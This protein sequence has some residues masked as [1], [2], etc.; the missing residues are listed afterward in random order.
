MELS[1][2]QETYFLLHLHCSFCLQFCYT[3]L[4]MLFVDPDL[5]R[6]KR[7]LKN[8]VISA[9]HELP[10]GQLKDELVNNLGRYLSDLK[11]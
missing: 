7:H 10:P 9:V 4:V 1:V 11:M 3:E 6:R 2:P 8:A 5:K